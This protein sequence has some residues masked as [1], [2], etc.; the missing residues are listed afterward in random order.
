MYSIEFDQSFK[1][2]YKRCK[3]KKYDLNLFIECV[4]L[5]ETTGKLPQKYR[6]HSLLGNYKGFMECHI[7]S[8]WLLIWLQDDENKVITL[9]RMGKHDDLF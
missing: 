4:T 3:K 5:L 1:S 9:V 7:K 6:P 2:D 8:D